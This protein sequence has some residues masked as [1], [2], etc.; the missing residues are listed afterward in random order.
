[1]LFKFGWNRTNI[2]NTLHEYLLAFLLH[3]VYYAQKC[4]NA[5]FEILK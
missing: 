1:M 5:L 4:I 3:F 2:T